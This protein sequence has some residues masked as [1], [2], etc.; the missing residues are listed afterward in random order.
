MPKALRL[1]HIVA[2]S[3]L[4][5]ACGLLGGNPNPPPPPV[6]SPTNSGSP[7]VPTDT[8]QVEVGI[9]PI[10]ASPTPPPPSGAVMATETPVPTPTPTTPLWSYQVQAGS[11]TYLPNL[12]HGNKDCNW[13]G[14]GG[15]VLGVD[16]KPVT[17]FLVVEVSGRI[18]GLPINELA[19]VNMA[20]DYGEG[21]F[22][23]TLANQPLGSTGALQIRLYDANLNPLSAP[24]TFDTHPS[25]SENLIL[26]QFTANP[27][28]FPTPTPTSTPTNT[29]FVPSHFIYLPLIIR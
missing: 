29:P 3:F 11:P 20:P 9:P 26:F 27:A 6:L 2:L 12:F 10:P 16:G 17:D 15:Q 24:F 25:C 28:A 5:S 4:L 14:D 13:M 7:S 19:G 21:G 8:P 18:A 22:E 23:I 1:Y